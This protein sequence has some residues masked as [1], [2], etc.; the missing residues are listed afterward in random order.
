[1]E[2]ESGEII[3]F[4]HKLLLFWFGGIAWVALPVERL[5]LVV[6]LLV[7]S[8]PEVASASAAASASAS[9]SAPSLGFARLLLRLRPSRS[10]GNRT[11]TLW[12]RL[13]LGLG[14][15]RLHM[16]AIGARDR[17]VSFGLD[18]VFPILAS[19]IVAS[20]PATTATSCASPIGSGFVSDFRN[21]RAYT[22]W[23]QMY[24]AAQEGPCSWRWRWRSAEGG[25]LGLWLSPYPRLS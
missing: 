21:V 10:S 1:M 8:R 22:L 11:L 12:L 9:S 20:E 2:L 16:L 23:T 4:H 14:R 7:S 6:A 15:G 3:L 25:L 18:R 17:L 5:A 24:P 13:G 19:F